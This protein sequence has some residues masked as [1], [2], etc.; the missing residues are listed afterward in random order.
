M[1]CEKN[2]QRIGRERLRPMIGQGLSERRSVAIV[3][4]SASAYRDQKRPDRNVGRRVRI[5]DLGQRS[6]RFGV[7]M[8]YCK[9]RHRRAC[10]PPAGGAAVSAR[11][12]T[13][14]SPSARKSAFGRS[15]TVVSTIKSQHSVVDGLRL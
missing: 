3:A 10:E 7:G 9:R 1:S 8:I 14:M 15:A 5:V 11:T 2:R 13:G 4:M 12:L 6:T